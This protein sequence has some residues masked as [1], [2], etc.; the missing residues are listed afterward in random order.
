MFAFSFLGSVLGGCA[1]TACG[2]VSKEAMQQSARVAFCILFTLAMVEA[3]VLRDFAQPLL[4]KLPCKAA[5][6]ASLEYGILG[7]DWSEHARALQ[8]SCGTKERAGPRPSMASKRCTVSA[9]AT[10]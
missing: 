4:E 2:F 5:A 9:S 7:G 8:G 6:P 3:W 1:C 10:S